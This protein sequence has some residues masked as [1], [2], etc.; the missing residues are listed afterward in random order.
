MLT[1]VTELFAD[2][3]GISHS[4]VCLPSG[5]MFQASSVAWRP[6]LPPIFHYL[7]PCN[8]SLSS[9]NLFS[10]ILSNRDTKLSKVSQQEMQL[11]GKLAQHIHSLGFIPQPTPLAVSQSWC[12]RPSL[13]SGLTRPQTPCWTLC[14]RVPMIHVLW[15]LGGFEGTEKLLKPLFSLFPV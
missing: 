11:S 7:N 3:L 5:I 14:S 4:M 2:A 15:D 1:T 10:N 9:L 6:I 12:G 13:I 8:I